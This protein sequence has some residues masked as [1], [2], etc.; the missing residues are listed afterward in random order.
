MVLN[1][2][3]GCNRFF[4]ERKKN[5]KKDEAIEVAESLTPAQAK[6]L[7]T[8]ATQEDWVEFHAKLNRRV[9]HALAD[10]KLAKIDRDDEN[11]KVCPVGRKVA[12]YL[13]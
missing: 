7:S 13:N 3:V 6:A 10:M 5:M 12:K 9:G 2:V 8:L 1:N 11:I 4:Y